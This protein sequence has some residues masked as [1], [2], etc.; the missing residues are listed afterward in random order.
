MDILDVDGFV[1]GGSGWADSYSVG[2]KCYMDSTF[3]HDIDKVDVNTP[4]G[5]MSILDLF[6]ML[7][8]GPGREGH[9]LYNDIQCGNGPS[10]GDALKDEIP[11]PGLV[12]YGLAGCGQIGPLWNL[13]EL[14]G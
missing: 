1:P 2:D 6:N 7:E 3:D 10:N 12:E 13:T 11:C 8:S 9:P 14:D 4:L 5:I